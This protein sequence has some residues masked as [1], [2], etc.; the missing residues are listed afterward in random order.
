MLSN[1]VVNCFQFFIFAVLF[2]VL[3]KM[4]T[5][6]SSCE[7]LSVLYICGVIHS[8]LLLFRICC[9]VV[10]CFQFFIFAVLFTVATPLL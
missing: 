6:C 2:T 1:A 5:L 8:V 3:K 7:L 10:N 9:F 4:P